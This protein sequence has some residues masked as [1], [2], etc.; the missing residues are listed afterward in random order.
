M[1]ENNEFMSFIDSSISFNP[2]YSDIKSRIDETKFRKK[3]KRKNDLIKYCLYVFYSIFICVVSVLITNAIKEKKYSDNGNR[4]TEQEIKEKFDVFFA[5]GIGDN[6]TLS[7]LDVILQSNIISDI[8]KDVLLDYK[9]KSNNK[10]ND[11]GVYL[12]KKDNKD[13]VFLTSLNDSNISFIFNSNLSY[14]YQ[15]VINEFIKKSNNDN[16]QDYGYS[17]NEFSEDIEIVVLFKK[18]NDLYVPYYTMELNG[19]VYIVE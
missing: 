14:S 2:N 15:D 8:D 11:F 7:T 6:L 19:K 10:Y 5:Y 18:V 4:L 16:I 12:G 9:N 3:P 17:S 1:K 13:I